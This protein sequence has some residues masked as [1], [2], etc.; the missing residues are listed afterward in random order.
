MNS[1][2]GSMAPTSSLDDFPH[3]PWGGW[4]H[5]IL[6]QAHASHVYHMEAIHIFI[7]CHSIADLALINMLWKEEQR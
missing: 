1:K 5:G 2:A 4:Q 3:P 6:V 7:R